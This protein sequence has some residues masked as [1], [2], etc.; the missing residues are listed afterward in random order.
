MAKLKSKKKVYV[1]D[2]NVFLSDFNAV[3]AF[4]DNDIVVPLKVLEEIDKHKKRQDGVGANARQVI[5][6]FDGLREKG[7]LDKGVKIGG[8][9]GTLI[10]KDFVKNTLPVE[11]NIN[12]PDN[13]ILATVKSVMADEE[14]AGGGN[15]EV[16]LVS[17]DINMRVK[18]DALG[19]QA[20]DYTTNKIVEMKEEI[21]TG[22]TS[23]LVDDALIDRFYDGE[24]LFLE[25][26]DIKLH[27]NQYVMLVSNANEKKTALCKFR[28]YNFALTKVR[29]FKEGVWDVRAKNKEQQFAFDMLMDDNI[30]IVSLVGLAGC[31]KTLIALAA[32]LE[33]TLASTTYKKI[34]VSRPVQPMG[35][36]IGFLP[37]TLEE[38]MAPWVAPIQDNLEFLMG[39]DKEHLAMLQE[40]G[41][42]EVEALTFIRGRSIA[43]AF[44]IIDEAQNLTMHELKT[45][46]TRVGEGTKI[47]L[48]GDVEQIDSS[49]LDA[50]NNG[51]TYAVEKFKPYELTGHITLQKGERSAVA[52]LAASVL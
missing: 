3:Y 26:K 41:T 48:T 14:D 1:I 52:T 23:H 9:K 37:G 49:F 28:N 44:I 32:A 20:Q 24:K 29:E 35:R 50:T 15:R 39:D 46:I 19:I 43:N 45:I 18:A 47:V 17:Q 22:F 51:L 5:R 2:T 11:M 33:Q 40:K 34:I 27:P 12:D 8:R 13:Q 4:G 30:K 21:Y 16:Y 7:Q 42:I 31:G 36:D 10:V 6:I 25:E 38:K